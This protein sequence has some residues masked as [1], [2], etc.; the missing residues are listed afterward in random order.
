MIDYQSI[1]KSLDELIA[2]QELEYSKETIDLEK[3]YLQGVIRGLLKAKSIVLSI[4]LEDIDEF[5]QKNYSK[6]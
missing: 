2:K 4:E 3:L 1:Y 6:V 5:V